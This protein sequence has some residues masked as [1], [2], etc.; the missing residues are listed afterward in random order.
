[1][2]VIAES[3]SKNSGAITKYL[4]L[5]LACLILFWVGLMG[6]EYPAYILF[7]V[8]AVI[9]TLICLDNLKNALVL[10]V[11]LVPIMPN[12]IVL[13]LGSGS[14]SVFLYRILMLIVL[15]VFFSGLL[16][17]LYKFE[18]SIYHLAGYFFIAV[19]MINV[20]ASFQPYSSLKFAF[21]ELWIPG[22]LFFFVSF[23][24]TSSPEYAEK[25][26][27][28]ALYAAIV[29]SVLGFYEFLT[30]NSIEMS[31]LVD[32]FCPYKDEIFPNGWGRGLNL[33]G[34]MPRAQATLRHPLGMASYLMFLFP[35]A[36]EYAARNKGKWLWFL[37]VSAGLFV[38]LSRAGLFLAGAVLGVKSRRNPIVVIGMFVVIMMVIVPFYQSAGEKGGNLL[39]LADDSSTLSRFVRLENG[40]KVFK[41]YPLTGVGIGQLDIEVFDMFRYRSGDVTIAALL[42]ETGI[43]GV[44]GWF[45]FFIVF[46]VKMFGFVRRKENKIRW[47]A[48][49][50]SAAMVIS[51]ISAMV[52]NSIFQYGQ[53]YI[54]MMVLAG[55]LARLEWDSANKRT[56]EIK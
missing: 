42:E 23:H 36:M 45:T 40:I 21:N 14:S 50:M 32:F 41:M 31:W 15:V 48:M 37:T 4:G 53:A 12:S 28:A 44:A 33:R 9:F 8:T 49:G 3:L 20:I 13:P 18:W 7:P 35:L 34:G 47:A 26:I 51:L 2:T 16:T 11:F 19:T 39:M 30:G 22:V 52:S 29:I 56:P 6:A 27:K 43:L 10:M 46:T 1:M 55:S 25:L 38:T 54:V 17:R 5:F 24:L